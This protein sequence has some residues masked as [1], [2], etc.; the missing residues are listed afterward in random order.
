M[1]MRAR[2]RL[3]ISSWTIAAE[4]QR[5]FGRGHRF[6]R[7]SPVKRLGSASRTEFLRLTGRAAGVLGDDDPR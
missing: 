7:Q 5:M 3:V 2:A 4:Y 6:A 1:L